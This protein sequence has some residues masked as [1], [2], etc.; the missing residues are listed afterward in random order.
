LSA[1]VLSASCNSESSSGQIMEGCT[2]KAEPAKLVVDEDTEPVSVSSPCLQ[3]ADLPLPSA[4][5]AGQTNSNSSLDANC[6][7][8][9]LASSANALL[10][11]DLAN[12]CSQTNITANPAPQLGDGG[13]RE[14]SIENDVEADHSQSETELNILNSDVGLQSPEVLDGEASVCSAAEEVVV[15]GGELPLS[16]TEE[17]DAPPNLGASVIPP[18]D[19]AQQ[20]NTLDNELNKSDISGVEMAVRVEESD[21]A[22]LED[23]S[24]QQEPE[25]TSLLDTEVSDSIAV[26]GET[27]NLSPDLDSHKDLKATEE[28][29]PEEFVAQ[30]S[31]N[32]TLAEASE[33]QDGDCFEKDDATCGKPSVVQEESSPAIEKTEISETESCNTVDLADD[34]IPERITV[35]DIEVVVK[36]SSQVPVSLETADEV[37]SEGS[38]LDHN[39]GLPL[40]TE[41]LSSQENE[42]NE[43]TLNDDKKDES[44]KE[45]AEQLVGEEAVGEQPITEERT[46]MEFEDQASGVS[47]E[48]NDSFITGIETMSEEGMCNDE[49]LS[50]NDN[51]QLSDDEDSVEKTASKDEKSDNMVASEINQSSSSLI[52]ES[53]VLQSNLSSVEDDG[54]KTVEDGSLTAVEDVGLTAVEDDGLTAVEDVGLTAVE[55]GGLTTVEDDGLETV[56]DVGLATAGDG[57]LTAVEDDGLTAVEDGGL[58]AAEDVGL[59]AV[60][61]DGLTAV[62]DDGLTA[63]A[64]IVLSGTVD[65]KTE[66]SL[67]VATHSVSPDSQSDNADDS[68]FVSNGSQKVG[69]V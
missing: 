33:S 18:V 45:F 62:E 22:K 67:E 43:Q 40:S 41:P 2:V 9:S 12:S 54:L 53:D 19:N 35:Q 32:F 42:S 59:T 21:S 28:G 13:F 60:E 27:S 65:C 68:E 8:M 24:S 23:V 69:V 17:N 64:E 7:N 66:D 1:S 57:G 11:N 25:S 56:E 39:Q 55:D 52:E 34:L 20:E 38:D 47:T 4:D 48:K 5:G 51:S 49:T 50:I 26:E 3:S 36:G 63:G 14:T 46:L 6:S 30:N 31:E 15:D 58:T 44:I 37:K 16:L 61:D 10:S 29:L